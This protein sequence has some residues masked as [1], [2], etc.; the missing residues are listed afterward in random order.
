M[1]L[2]TGCVFVLLADPHGLLVIRLKELKVV[3][4][5][6]SLPA[7]LTHVKHCSDTSN[8]AFPLNISSFFFNKDA[9]RLHKLT[10][11]R[12][13]DPVQVAGELLG[14]VGL[15]SGWQAHHHD[16][17]GTVTELRN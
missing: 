16:H 4:D 3:V 2:V 8:R 14:D 1:C 9:L 6:D 10:F 13:A 17:R 5:L 11:S 12:H 15:P 7:V